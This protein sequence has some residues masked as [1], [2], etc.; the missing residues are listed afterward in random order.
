MELFKCHAILATNRKKDID[1][2][3]L[4]RLRYIMDFPLPGVEQ[5]KKIWRQVIPKAIRDN[6]KINFDFLGKQFPLSGGHIRS[7]IFNACLQCAN[8]SNGHS[9]N[10]LTMEHII[11]AVKREYDKLNRSISLEHFGPYAEVIK[12]LERKDEKH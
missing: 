10:L 2:A 8:G 12:E 3:F 7:I 11:I 1:E 6:S 4:R 5:R 9:E